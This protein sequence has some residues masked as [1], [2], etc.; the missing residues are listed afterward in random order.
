M[1]TQHQLLEGS[2]GVALAALDRRRD[3]LQGARVAVVICG[4]NISLDTLKAI[5]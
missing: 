4:A 3:Q 2:A 1:Q 5:L